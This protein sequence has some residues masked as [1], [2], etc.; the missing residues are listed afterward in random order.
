LF[1][2]M[3]G[4]AAFARRSLIPGMIAHAAV[5]VIGGLAAFR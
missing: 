1:G 3:F 4:L 2:L 5:D